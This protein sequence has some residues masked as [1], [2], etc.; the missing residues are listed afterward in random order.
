LGHALRSLGGAQ[1][2]VADGDGQ[3]R[4]LELGLGLAG[5]G[6]SGFGDVDFFGEDGDVAFWG[7][8]V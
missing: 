3:A 1:D 7:E 4:L 5:G 2:G 6:F 8:Q